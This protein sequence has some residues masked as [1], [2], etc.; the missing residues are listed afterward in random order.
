M[1]VHLRHLCVLACSL[2]CGWG[3]CGCADHK[4]EYYDYETAMRSQS[5]A[6]WRGKLQGTF[7]STKAS[8]VLSNPYELLVSMESAQMVALRRLTLT[9]AG[10]R[11]TLLD[12]RDPSPYSEASGGRERTQYFAF[13]SL[14]IEEHR[15]VEVKLTYQ[16]AAGTDSLLL[17]LSK[18]YRSFRSNRIWDILMGV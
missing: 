2:S 6:V 7:V 3:I 11:D 9:D 8:T 13:D 1:R 5:G 10:G 18:H 14:V 16:T 17:M 15:D 12:V 4:N